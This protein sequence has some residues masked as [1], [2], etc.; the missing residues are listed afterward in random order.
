MA[1]S[2]ERGSYQ[3]STP[4][5]GPGRL[6]RITRA[7][8]KQGSGT[9][10][11]AAA[12]GE[13]LAAATK[14]GPGVATAVP[15]RLYPT[16]TPIPS[17]TTSAT[18]TASQLG[19]SGPGPSRTICSTGSRGLGVIGAIWCGGASLP[20]SRAVCAMGGRGLSRVAPYAS[21]EPRPAIWFLIPY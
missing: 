7:T 12:V 1:G 6:W 9:N 17:V 4:E 5:N 13:T 8:I 2:T 16:P 18:S 19:Q 15:R 10:A 20:P 3:L 14:L 11:T 21:S